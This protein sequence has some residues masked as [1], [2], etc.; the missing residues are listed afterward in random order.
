MN[1]ETILWLMI[2]NETG[3]GEPPSPGWEWAPATANDA[4]WFHERSLRI[5]SGWWYA[6][7]GE[8]RAI[9][10]R[11]GDVWTFTVSSIA[12]NPV[13]TYATGA[14][15]TAREAMEEVDEHHLPVPL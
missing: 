8:R 11:D 13:T 15:D 6:A 1:T 14:A 3:K 4:A 9:V 5:P 7:R 12:T 2:Q 10:Q